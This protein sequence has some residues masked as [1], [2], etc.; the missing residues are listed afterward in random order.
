MELSQINLGE[1]LTAASLAA[2]GVVAFATEAMKHLPP[3]WTSRYPVYI[4]IALSFIGAIVVTGF[5]SF[6]NWTAFLVQ[7]AAIALTAAIG[8]T[9]LIKPATN[10]TG[11]GDR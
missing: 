9:K 1:L 10:S 3:E 11:A 7:W 4:N 8:Y 2:A 5:P 6:D